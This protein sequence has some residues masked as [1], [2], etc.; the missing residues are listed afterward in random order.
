[1]TPLGEPEYLFADAVANFEESEVVLLGVPFDGTS[2]H[3]SGSAQA[4]RAIRQESYNF[5]TF[6]YKYNLNLEDVRIHDMGDTKNF[7]NISELV[8]ELPSVIQDVIR[9]GKFLLTLGGEH[10]ITIPVIE[11]LSEFNKEKD[12]EI[13]VV[14]LDAHLDFR[15]SYLDEKYSH[16]SV[17]CRLAELVGMDK[18]VS[19]GIRS[20]SAEEAKVLEDTKLR[21]YDADSINDL[22]IEKIPRYKKYLFI[23]GYGCF[24]S[25]LCTGCR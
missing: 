2:S 24:R 6:L 17:A 7:S 25:R 21:I 22:G 16:A 8:R 13:G 19:V 11:T 9:L 20:Y 3:R 15:D 18:I 14:Y 1:M 4:P 10:S 12:Q 5:E 23:F